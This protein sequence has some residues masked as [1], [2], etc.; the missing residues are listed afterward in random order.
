MPMPKVVQEYKEQAK[1]RIIDTARQIFSE[2]GYHET[3]MEDVGK[4]LGVSKGALYLY[5]P[6]KEELF[7][8]IVEKWDRTIREM[9]LSSFEDKK[10]TDGLGDLIDHL[11]TDREEYIGLTFEFISQASR[12]PSIRKILRENYDKNVKTI[13]AFLEKKRA[14]N[15]KANRRNTHLQASA[16][17]ALLIGTMGS[18][19]L[20]DE[21]T[22]VRQ[23]WMKSTNAILAEQS[24]LSHTSRNAT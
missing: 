11:L 14:K 19:I 1:S 23:T 7:K 20:G 6:S 10:L 21:K 13:T 18:L 16:L 15:P 3:T 2:K 5:F 8:A 4:A 12:D 24:K 9:L 22:E 17:I